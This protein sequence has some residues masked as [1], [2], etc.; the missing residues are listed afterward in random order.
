MQERRGRQGSDP[1]A[2]DSPGGESQAGAKPRYYV[3]DKTTKKPFDNNGQSYDSREQALQSLDEKDRANA[4]VIEVPAG[5]LVLRAESTTNNDGEEVKPDR[6]W[7][8]QDRPGL[9]G[10]DI[11]NPEQSAD[12]NLGNEPI[13][14]FNFTD[15]GRKA[16]Q[17]ITRARRPARRRQRARRRPDLHLAALRDRARQRAGLGAVHQL[18]REPGRHRRRDR[19]ADLRQLH[20]QVRAG[21][22]QDPQDRRPAAEARPRSRA[23]RSPRR[24][25][26]RRST[27]A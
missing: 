22:G 10:T 16:F 9:S 21:P 20:D 6:W 11:K 15:K 5:V 19:R 26:S 4:E 12:T 23:R 27:R 13:V 2:E 3:F 24:S 17:A 1:L 25:A 8:I 18:A 14:T 7:V